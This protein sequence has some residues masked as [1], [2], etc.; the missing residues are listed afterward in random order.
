MTSVPSGLRV[1]IT[2]RMAIGKDSSPHPGRAGARLSVHIMAPARPVPGLPDREL[3]RTDAIPPAPGA[4]E[5]CR[6][7]CRPALAT[8]APLPRRGRPR[9]APRRSGRWRRRRARRTGT[10]P[11]TATAAGTPPGPASRGRTRHT[12][13]PTGPAHRR[14]CAPARSCRGTP[15]TGSRPAASGTRRPRRSARRRPA[16]RRRRRPRQAARTPRASRPAGWP[17]RR[18]WPAGGPRGFRGGLPGGDPLG[19]P[20]GHR[21]T[22]GKHAGRRSATAAGSARRLATAAGLATLRAA[23]PEVY[24][25]LDGAAAAV[26][27]LAS[28]ALTAAGVEYRMQQAGNLFSVFLGTSGPVRSFADARAQSGRAYAAFFHAMLDRGVYLPPSPFEAWFLSAA[29]DDAAI[30]RIGEALPG[31]ARAAAAALG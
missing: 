23:T 15:R 24:A 19:Q 17:A 6:G 1:L 31:A 12:R 30:A 22:A 16:W 26:A 18:R 4:G 2:L 3:D 9:E 20:A 7:N 29:H 8:R 10:T 13:G 27:K 25:R 14:S 5:P 28:D 11:R 21:R